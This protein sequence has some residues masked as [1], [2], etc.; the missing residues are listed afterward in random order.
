M[1]PLLILGA[2]VAVTFAAIINFKWK[3]SIHD[4]DRRHHRNIFGLSTF[5]LVDVRFPILFCPLVAGLLGACLSLGAHNA[6]ANLC[7]LPRR[8]P[9]RIPAVKH[10][11]DQNVQAMPM[12]YGIMS[13]DLSFFVQGAG[14]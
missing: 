4:R 6:H 13:P 3:I 14:L 2:A 10:L 12:E 5:L 7:R 1:F 9:L 11:N 8:I